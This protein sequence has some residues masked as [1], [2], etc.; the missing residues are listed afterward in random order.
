MLGADFDIAPVFQHAIRA[1]VIACM[2]RAR[3]AQTENE[4]LSLVPEYIR[5]SYA[6]EPIDKPI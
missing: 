6:Q 2:A 5:S 1:G 4:L 3:L